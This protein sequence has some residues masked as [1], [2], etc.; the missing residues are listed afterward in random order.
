M[1]HWGAVGKGRAEE[2]GGGGG[3]QGWGRLDSL[4]EGAG[5]RKQPSA[6][7]LQAQKGPGSGQEKHE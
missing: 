4:Q 5:G 6:R 2:G 3:A 1:S 7:P